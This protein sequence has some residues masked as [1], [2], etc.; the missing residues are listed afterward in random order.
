MTLFKLYNLL[1]CQVVLDS[2]DIVQCFGF[3]SQFCFF[4]S[5]FY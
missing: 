5:I 2:I 4:C 1:L 3:F